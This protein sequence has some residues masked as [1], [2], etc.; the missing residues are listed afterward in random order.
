ML[1][2][3]VGSILNSELFY[4][5]VMAKIHSLGDMGFQYYYSI[6]QLKPK[7]KGHIISVKMNFQ[8][9]DGLQFIKEA[10][11]N[12]EDFI[13]Y[14]NKKSDGESILNQRGDWEFWP[15]IETDLEIFS[16]PKHESFWVT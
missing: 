5:N 15:T 14:I 7:L 13:I 3:N 10:K 8:K 9:P 2:Q 16:C 11:L 4:N 12:D 6:S 1:K